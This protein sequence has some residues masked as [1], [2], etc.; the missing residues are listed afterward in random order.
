MTYDGNAGLWA[1]KPPSV[2]PTG[3]IL[4]AFE[5]L[6]VAT[7]GL[8]QHAQL[9]LDPAEPSGEMLL[10]ATSVPVTVGGPGVFLQGT[11]LQ[12]RGIDTTNGPFGVTLQVVVTDLDGTNFLLAEVTGELSEN[13]PID[14]INLTLAGASPEILGSELSLDAETGNISTTGTG[15]YFVQLAASGNY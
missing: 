13:T 7:P 12:M 2:L 14:E 10:M 8:A 9:A 5:N 15:P 1:P 3:T 11:L 4:S 6:A